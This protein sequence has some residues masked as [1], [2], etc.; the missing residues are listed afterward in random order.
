MLWAVLIIGANPQA[1]D[2]GLKSPLSGVCSWPSAFPLLALSFFFKF[3][4]AVT[5]DYNIIYLSGYI[6][7]YY[8][9]IYLSGYII[10]YFEFCA[11]YIMCSLFLNKHIS[12]LSCG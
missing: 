6:V 5:L 4:T 9:I 11:D 3:F 12:V 1:L 7:I 8:N 10:I 2:W